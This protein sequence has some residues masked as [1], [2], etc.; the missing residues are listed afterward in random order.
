MSPNFPLGNC[1]QTSASSK[2]SDILPPLMFV[3]RVATALLGVQQLLVP[4]VKTMVN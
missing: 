1:L 2:P 4:S 3:L